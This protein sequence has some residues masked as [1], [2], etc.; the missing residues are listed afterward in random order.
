L[1]LNG[2]VHLARSRSGTLILTGGFGAALALA[3]LVGRR[4]VDA[5]WPFSHGH[6]GLLVAAGLLSLLGYAL[7]A[8]GC[9]RLFAAG[10]RPPPLALAAANG[11]ASVT[12]IALPGR[13][14]D[15]VRIAR[16][17]SPTR[18]HPESAGRERR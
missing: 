3:I 10:D 13:F 7:K 1:V 6:P 12:G 5:S 11:G 17:S 16:S 15:V 4:F 2:L 18:Q 14:D 8:Y 9:R